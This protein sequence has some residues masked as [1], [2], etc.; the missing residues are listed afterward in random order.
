MLGGSEI[1][2]IG[3]AVVFLLFG[4]SI[5][6]NMGK[7][8]GESIREFRSIKK[9]LNEPVELIDKPKKGRP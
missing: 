2:I 3:G 9:E 8:A 5:L 7:A 1:L 4:P 6:K